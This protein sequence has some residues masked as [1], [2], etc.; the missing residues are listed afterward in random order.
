[1]HGSTAAAI[2]FSRKVGKKISANTVQ[3]IKKAYEAETKNKRKADSD[4]EVTSLPLKKTWSPIFAGG[5]FGQ[6]VAVVPEE[7]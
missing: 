2:F 7:G 3:S 6:E 1:M 5:G 4:D